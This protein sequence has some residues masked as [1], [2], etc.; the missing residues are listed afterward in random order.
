MWVAELLGSSQRLGCPIRAR[1]AFGSPGQL[2]LVQIAFMCHM[3]QCKYNHMYDGVAGL[4][5]SSQRL[6]SLIIVTQH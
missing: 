5:G 6:G 1:V 3:C 2:S 4:P